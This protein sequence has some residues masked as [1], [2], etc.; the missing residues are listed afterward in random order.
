M[1]D[2]MNIDY[3]PLPKH[4]RPGMKR[5][6]EHGEVPGNFLTAV[7][8]NKLMQAVSYADPVNIKKLPA[9]ASFLFNHA[10]AGCWGSEKRVLEWAKSGGWLGRHPEEAV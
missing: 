9:Y 7:L 2:V 6:V 1:S 4:T 8:E 3:S 10:P 5:W